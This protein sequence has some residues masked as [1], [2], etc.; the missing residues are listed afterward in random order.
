MHDRITPEVLLRQ[1]PSHFTMQ[2]YSVSDLPSNEADECLVLSPSR[3]GIPFIHQI[4]YGE[5]STPS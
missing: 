5:Q 1:R 4:L 3:S 2:E